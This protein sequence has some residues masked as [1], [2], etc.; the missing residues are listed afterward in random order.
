MKSLAISAA[1]L[2]GLCACNTSSPEVQNNHWHPYH[3][4]TDVEAYFFG[5]D[6]VRDGSYGNRFDEDMASL[7]LTVERYILCWNPYNPLLP[8]HVE[9]YEA[10]PIP[11]NPYRKSAETPGETTAETTVQ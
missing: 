11:E 2:G 9:H 6:Y 4:V 3:I 7:W 1:L 10:P 8:H 5:Y